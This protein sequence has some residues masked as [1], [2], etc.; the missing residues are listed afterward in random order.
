MKW[1]SLSQVLRQGPPPA[2]RGREKACGLTEKTY[3]RA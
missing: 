1:E 2:K 3:D